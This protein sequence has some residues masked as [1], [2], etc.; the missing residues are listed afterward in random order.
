VSESASEKL[1]SLVFGSNGVAVSARSSAPNVE[2][3]VGSSSS[4]RGVGV[5]PRPLRTNSGSPI[6]SRRRASALLTAG[7]VTCK[8]AAARA[9]LR[10]A[11]TACSVKSRLRSRFD[12]FTWVNYIVNIHHW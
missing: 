3:N 10:S 4:A 12:R 2:V 8:R 11:S 5:S 6:A 7:E 9:T 1:R